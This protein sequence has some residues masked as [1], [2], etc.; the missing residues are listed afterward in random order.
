MTS[1]HPYGVHHLS[2]RL[3]R[4][5]VRAL[6]L[7]TALLATG[8]AVLQPGAQP[9][10]A[11]DDLVSN[12]GLETLDG[13]GFPRCF[14][15]A[16]WGDQDVTYTVTGADQAHSGDHAVRIDMTRRAGGDR[17]TMMRQDACAPKAVPGHSYDL[18]LWYRSTSPDVALTLFRH[19]TRAGWV[20]WTD[21]KTLPQ[22]GSYTRTEVRTPVVPDNTDQ[23]TWGAALYGVGTLITDDYSMVDM[24]VPPPEP[25][26]DPCAPA[27]TPDCRGQWEVKKAPAPLRAIHTVLL[28]TGKVLLIAGSG[29][30]E[31]AF[32]A[33]TFKTAVYDPVAETFTDVPTPDDFFC[34]GHVQLP[35]G[36][37]LVMGGNKDYASPDGSVGYRGL[38]VS[39]V[40][41]PATNRYTRI[42]DLNAGHWYPSA[43]E[44]GNGD[45]LSL[46]GLGEDSAGTVVNEHYSAARGRWL[47]I[48]DAK[49]AWTFWG[50]YPAMILLQ[51]GRLFYTGSH[52]FGGGL[53]TTG[54]SVYDYDKGTVTEIPGLRRKDERDQS[55]SLLL[56]P[57]QDQKVLTLGGGNHTVAPDAH[58]LV[59]LIDMK[60]ASPR[61][62]PGPDLP[63]GT[64]ADGSRQKGAEGKVYASAVILPDGKVLETGGA[65]HT[66]RED[67]VF[68][69]SLYDPATNTFASHLA[70]DPV[71]RTYHS[72]SVLLPDGRVLSVGDNPA[73]GSFDQRISVFSPPYLF[74]GAR[75]RITSVAPGTWAYGSTRRITVD[76]PVVKASLIRPAA[77]THS[78]DPNQ[79]YVDL[80]MT[81][82]GTTIDLSL[83]SN[84]NLA[85]PGWYMLSVVDAAGVPSVSSWV[86]VGPQGQVAAARVQR[87]ADELAAP[88]PGAHP[89][90][91]R[92]EEKSGV[93][94][95]EGYDGC[96]HAYG[97]VGQ[98]VPWT[99]P[100]TETGGRCDWLRERGFGPLRVHGRDRHRL[101]TDRSGVACDRGDGGG[102]GGGGPGRG[103]GYH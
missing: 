71:P 72:S 78:S 81:V 18:S 63:Q 10:R 52:V 94:V 29:N 36:R 58:R 101:D 45:V 86:R 102:G 96:D 55:M 1:H 35:D 66:Y 30:D 51:D 3:Q 48:G 99:F 6:L 76:K 103:R 69:A 38:K 8:L 56:P 87:F 93:T 16:G 90:H 91:G 41:D 95:P 73:N 75:P 92:A 13:D 57:A 12:P 83:T 79:R 20:F 70:T 77:V 62:L 25:E 64:Y 46:G 37:V 21:L 98:C 88:R 80:P 42:N 100:R 84:P 24:T 19:D 60:A 11:A 15:K 33:G 14:E 59:D 26:P 85:P 43:T 7:V 23:I 61:Y 68:E 2:R 89:Q 50:L 40:F 74:K 34:A 44:L 97:D 47:G 82:D 4:A 53:G 17:K 49:Q 65:L 39:Y 32:R 5:K 54:A 67:P 31:E 27:G 28:H 22:A 9:A